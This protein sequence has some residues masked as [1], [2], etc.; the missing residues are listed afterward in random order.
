VHQV[1]NSGRRAVF[2]A[3][4][5]RSERIRRNIQSSIPE[6]AQLSHLGSIWGDDV[7]CI[8]CGL[9]IEQNDLAYQL[10]FRR[11]REI[12]TIKLHRECWES[13]RIDER[14]LR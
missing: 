1:H 8:G 12:A 11:N 3:S 10:E 9:A 6:G 4:H 5:L 13:W 2:A 14:P 7:E